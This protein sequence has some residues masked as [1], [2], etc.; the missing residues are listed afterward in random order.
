M[1]A[2]PS[3]EKA[4]STPNCMSDSLRSSKAFQAGNCRNRAHDECQRIDRSFPRRGSIRPIYVQKH[5]QSQPKSAPLNFALLKRGCSL[6]FES[7]EILIFSSFPFS[8]LILWQFPAATIGVMSPTL[9]QSSTTRVAEIFNFFIPI[10]GQ[11][12]Q[13]MKKNNFE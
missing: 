13:P 1:T 2:I 3:Q 8:A 10:V 11:A 7:N 6:M 5:A 9:P 12:V 4:Q